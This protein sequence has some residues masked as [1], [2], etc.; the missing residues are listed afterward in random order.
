MRRVKERFFESG[1]HVILVFNSEYSIRDEAL[2]DLDGECLR[3]SLKNNT[4]LKNLLYSLVSYES[5]G[6]FYYYFDD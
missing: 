4:P 5:P 6:Y 3:Y 2:K 1:E